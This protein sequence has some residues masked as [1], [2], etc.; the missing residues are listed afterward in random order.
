MIQMKSTPR[1]NLWLSTSTLGLIALSVW[2]FLWLSAPQPIP[3]DQP[4]ILP[5]SHIA[6]SSTSTAAIVATDPVISAL[7]SPKMPPV[8][9]PPGS[10]GEACE[11]NEFLSFDWYSNLDV[12]IRRSLESQLYD[13]MKEK[14][15]KET[16]ITAL[17]RHMY[18]INPYL[19]EAP[20]TRNGKT[21]NEENR[22]FSFVVI[23]N[24]L[25]FERIFGDPVGD[26]A[27]V[28]EALAHPDC[29][30]G[31]DAKSNYQLNETCH[32]DA[33]LNYAL[34]LRY[35]YDEHYIFEDKP[36]ITTLNDTGMFIKAKQSATKP[37]PE[38][39]RHKW[40]QE[41]EDDWL[42]DKCWSLDRTL[43]LNSELHTE[44]SRQIL[45]IM[46][47]RVHWNFKS[48]NAGLI[49][50]AARL[51]DEAAGLTKPGGYGALGS[52]EEGYKY[53]RFASWFT[54]VFDPYELFTKLSPS[55]ERMRQLVPLFGKNL[56]AP[57]GKFIQ[58]DHEALVQHL[59]TPPYYDTLNDNLIAPDPPSCR[60]IIN[61]LRQESLG[62]P[63]LEAI[64][65]F[66][67]VAMLLD[68]YE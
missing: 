67:D 18:S 56:G 61:E 42:R 68:V 46:P 10:V 66:E 23:D 35:C 4:A 17:E 2:V 27:R 51:G 30:F 29:Q 1:L 53:G 65:T 16:C 54:N 33:I 41:L 22:A 39:D 48:V 40:I 25:T 15:K 6:G 19:W 58:F 12:D 47:A 9:Y 21:Q 8:D 20:N 31:K 49:E 32:A 28:Q 38:E 26:F 37:T 55:V 14:L 45:A 24:P 64:A 3:P 57:G 11:V 34:V 63:M 59:C 5:N 50:L 52:T 7:V 60:E 44:L 43:D 13:L 62:P 36:T